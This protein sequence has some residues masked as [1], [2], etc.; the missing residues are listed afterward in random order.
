MRILLVTTWWPN[1]DQPGMAPFNVAHAKAIARHHDVHVVRVQ[2]KVA[3]RSDV[4][5]PS[6]LPL[7]TVSVNPADPV[8]SARGLNELRK[9][10]TSSD[11]VHTLAYDALTVLAPL[12][13]LIRKRWVHTEHWSAFVTGSAPIPTRVR[14]SLRLPRRVSTVSRALREAIQPMTRD[15]DITVI[16]NVIADHF[17]VRAQPA[18]E[19]LKLVS[20]GMLI[21]RKRPVLAVETVAEL[22]R[23]GI[24]TTLTWVG[25]GPLDE[26]VRERAA[27]L[28]VADRVRLTG[29]VPA[30]EVGG[31]LGEANVFFLPTEGETFLVAAAEAIASGRPVVLPELDCL[32]YVTEDN[33]VLVRDGDAQRFAA[34][35]TDV[36]K[37]FRDRDAEAVRSTVLPRFGEESVADDFDR[38]YAGLG[39]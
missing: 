34:A 33:G 7:T 4:T 9:L 38:F 13:P 12:A 14:K 35:I 26:V 1:E 25:E 22:V 2:R 37:T 20:V 29:A 8:A 36:S 28:G 27:E 32:D 3:P 11:I 6:G 10:V 16:P 24:D 30:R 17:A 5:D 15:P 19:P 21:E 39:L 31:Y 23:S 18:W